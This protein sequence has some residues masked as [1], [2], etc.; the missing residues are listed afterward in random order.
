ML[1]LLL[2]LPLLLLRP[3]EPRLL[4]ERAAVRRLLLDDEGALQDLDEAEAMA[5]DDEQIMRAVTALRAELE[6]S[7]LL[8]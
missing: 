1:L 2:L 6:R 4:V 8:H 3:L 5:D 7:Q